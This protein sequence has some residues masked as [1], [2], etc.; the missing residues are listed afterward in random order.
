LS[1]LVCLPAS[2][3]DDARRQPRQ[4]TYGFLLRPLSAGEWVSEETL[5]DR[6]VRAEDG[7]DFQRR[8]ASD[9]VVDSV[10]VDAARR[11]KSVTSVVVVRR[12]TMI[13]IGLQGLV[14]GLPSYGGGSRAAPGRGSR[15]SPCSPMQ[16]TT[17]TQRI[18]TYRAA[19][20][21]VPIRI[22]IP[23]YFCILSR[24]V[25]RSSRGRHRMWSLIDETD[26]SHNRRAAGAEPVEPCLLGVPCTSRDRRP[27]AR[28]V[29][30]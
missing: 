28:S 14:V 12:S 29:E 20:S 8:R 25:S 21:V 24:I 11:R 2:H 18:N 1:P 9:G 4:L 17:A 13:V 23:C 3:P 10:V 16:G 22:R 5:T 7:A 6:T 15:S 27:C 30:P 26:R 19:R